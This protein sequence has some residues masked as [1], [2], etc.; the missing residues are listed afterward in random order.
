MIDK[1]EYSRYINSFA[2][3]QKRSVALERAQYRCEICG[4]SKCSKTLEVH[5]KT[6]ERFQNELPTDLMVVCTE[7]HVEQ[8][9]I[10]AMQS[11]I[12]S[13]RALNEARFNGWASKKYGDDWEAYY[14]ADDL[15]EEFQE[16]LERKHGW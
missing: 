16:W 11:K 10:R 4:F 7:C 15:E 8:D 13:R 1:A 14:D 9:K 12:R 3:K 6:Y 2:W 5:H